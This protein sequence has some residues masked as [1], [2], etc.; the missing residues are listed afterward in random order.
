MG[1]METTRKEKT[2]LNDTVYCLDG[3]RVV[4][5]QQYA[6]YEV[7]QLVQDGPDDNLWDCVADTPDREWAIAVADEV[8]NKAP[9]VPEDTAGRYLDEPEVLYG[10]SCYLEDY[11]DSGVDF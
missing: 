6:V 3:I 9:Q 1:D 5:S 10:D 2:M 7:W 4:W 8:W 11:Y